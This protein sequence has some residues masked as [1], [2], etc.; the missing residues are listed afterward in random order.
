MKPA[1]L[2]PA[3]FLRCQM[4]RAQA[5]G[6]LGG[7]AVVFA[8][9]S[10]EKE[11]PN[12]DAVAL[13]PFREGEGVLAVA[14]GVGGYPGGENASAVALASLGEC[15][16]RAADSDAGLRTAI[17]DGIEAANRAVREDGQGGTTLAVAELR[18]GCVR[19]YHVGD[20][21]I[22]VTGQRGRVKLQTVP[23]SPVGYALE[24]GVLDEEQAMAHVDRHLIDNM[25]GTDDMRIEIGPELPLAQRDT[26]LLASDG[27]ADNLFVAEIIEHV[28]KGELARSAQGMAEAAQARMGSAREGLP[29][30]PDDLSFV[31]WRPR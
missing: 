30:K 27:L 29:S 12:E 26:L 13:I 9:R 31:A 18:A 8:S 3:Y 1:V 20:S 19:T 10:P 24:A 5:H 2:E 6:F 16:R 25:L 22:L 28:R 15:V 17:L 4:E 14:D 11:T 7:T 21:V 23:H